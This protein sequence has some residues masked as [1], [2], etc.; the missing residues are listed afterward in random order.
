MERDV[1]VGGREED[2]RLAGGGRERDER[3]VL[4]DV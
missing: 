4:G 3:M 1:R 2:K